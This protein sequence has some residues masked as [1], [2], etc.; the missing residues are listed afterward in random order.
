[1]KTT[2]AALAALSLIGCSG[3]DAETPRPATGTEAIAEVKAASSLPA[4]KYVSTTAGFDLELP[5]VWRARYRAEEKS[6]NT[7]GARLRVDFKFVPDSGSKAPSHTLMT[8]RVFSKAAWEAAKKKPGESIG[9]PLGESAKD[10]FVL[11]LPSSNP[12]PTASPEAPLFDKLIISLSAG[13][14]Q[15]H[16]TAR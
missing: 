11:S 6:D 15:V 1:M 16:L 8:V 2:I 5:G 12:Y 7:A 3:K 9:S 4:E 13:G 14:Q 10:V